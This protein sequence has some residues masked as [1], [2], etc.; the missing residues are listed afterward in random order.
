MKFPMTHSRIMGGTSYPSL[1]KSGWPSGDGSCLFSPRATNREGFDQIFIQWIELIYW[2]AVAARLTN[3]LGTSKAE[4]KRGDVSKEV[5][6]HMIQTETIL[7]MVRTAQC[8]YQYGDGIGI[9][10]GVTQ[11]R[12]ISL[13]CEPVPR[14]WP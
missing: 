7:N 11:D 3:D 1:G 4:M 9:S 6:C 8:I 14:Q 10:T 5:E 2:S 13:I 12:V